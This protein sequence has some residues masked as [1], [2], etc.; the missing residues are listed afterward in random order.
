M[1]HL[2]NTGQSRVRALS[3]EQPS[4]LRRVL[5]VDGDPDARNTILRYFADH[6]C[7][8]I[9]SVGGDVP[10]HL[11][12]NQ[13]SL[14]V[15]DGRSAPYDGFHTLRQIRAR[16]NVPVILVTGQHE[17]DIDSIVGLELGADDFLCEPLN[18]REL[19][20]R[21]RAIL[22]RL[23]MGRRSQGTS[24]QGGYRFDGW[25]LH[26][27]TRVLK[28]PAGATVDLTRK[29]FSLLMA[30]LEAPCRLLSREHLVWATRSHEDICDRSIDVQVLRLRRKIE[31]D[32]SA[33]RLIKTERNM[34][35]ILDASV[36]ILF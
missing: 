13:F 18:L 9:G 12:C 6:Q 34:G 27:R 7:I 22:R 24:P 19:L 15:L 26:H 10:R 5:V 31:A 29:E 17:N 30:F 21:A 35:Y 2:V 11:Q 28:A 33:P 36:E 14:V 1:H 23:E 4:S 3:L 20:A 16:S 25:E 8:A 32:P